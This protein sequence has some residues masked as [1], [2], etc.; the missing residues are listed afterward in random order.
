MLFSS[1]LVSLLLA[2]HL[3]VVYSSLKTVQGQPNFLHAI[4]WALVNLAAPHVAHYHLRATAQAQIGLSTHVDV[5]PSMC[6]A[7]AALSATPAERLAPDRAS[8]K[9]A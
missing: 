6:S 2:V 4:T 9:L 1:A 5:G 8:T 3:S 7:A